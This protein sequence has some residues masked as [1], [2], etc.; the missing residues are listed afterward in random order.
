MGKPRG[1]K[2][3]AAGLRRLAEWRSFLDIYHNSPQSE[4][5]KMLTHSGHGSVTALKLNTTQAKA[6]SPQ[7]ARVMIRRIT[8][9]AALGKEQLDTAAVCKQCDHPAGSPESLERH[10]TRCANGGQRHYMH[11]GLVALIVIIL[12]MSGVPKS[13]IVLEK[14]GL[15]PGNRSRPGDIVVLNFY[16]LGRHLV[17]DVVLC[18]VYRNVTLAQTCSIPGYAAKMAEDRKFYNDK[19]S[20]HPVSSK[21][22]GDH[23]LVPFAMEDGGTLGAHALA[24]LKQLAEFAV[25]H[26]SFC[27]PGSRAPLTA[28]MQVSL[29]VQR[30]QH[31]LSTWLHVTL[32]QQLLRMYH[33]DGAL[34]A[35][36]S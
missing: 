10:S 17:I 30:W 35:V 6:V 31:R 1:F 5:T 27:S 34:S 23:V 18:T 22:G 16:G 25:S 20:S 8:G 19:K 7:C 12:L 21:Y 28:P 33:P 26:G 14:K 24:L 15:R 29:W 9:S 4:Q 32:S 11:A 36:L 2:Q 3:I 13:S